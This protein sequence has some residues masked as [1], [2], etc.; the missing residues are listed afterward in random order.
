MG[1]ETD[2]QLKDRVGRLMAFL[3]VLVAAR[4]HPV[5]D[6]SS[7]ERVV[8]PLTVPDV[9]FDEEAL[10]GST[11][12][13]ANR[14]TLEAAP[15][16][17]AQLRPWL[18][19]GRYP[20][21][22]RPV[23]ELRRD[24]VEP[25]PETG[26]TR[27]LEP[28][29]ATIATYNGWRR[30]WSEWARS[31]QV[32]RPRHDFYQI[33]LTMRQAL[34]ERPESV[35]VVLAAGLL[36]VP[37]HIAGD[38]LRT[39]VLTQTLDVQLDEK[40]GDLLCTLPADSAPRLE[41]SQLLT[42][43]SIFDSSGSNYFRRQLSENVPSLATPNTVVFLKEWAQRALTVAVEVSAGPG[44][45]GASTLTTAPAI[46]LR[47]RGSAALLA[48]YERIIAS[49]EQPGSVVPLGLA[50]LVDAI[51]PEDRI[52][53]LERT[54]A[55]GAANLADDP[56]FPLPAN[57][58]QAQ[59][60]E[61]LGRDSG[62]V[63]EGPPG[64]GKTHTIANLMS[65]LLAQGQRV[66]VTSEKA[67]ALRV[68]REKLPPEM[69][70]LCVSITDIARGGSAELSRSVATLAARK[71][72]FNAATE[73]RRIDNLA[74]RRRQAQQERAL[75][76]EEIRSLRESETYQHPAVSDGYAGTA[77]AIARGVRAGAE[78][79]DW[80]PQ[81]AIGTAPL[82]GPE[83]AELRRLLSTGT[84]Q[85]RSRREQVLPGT[86]HLPEI[87]TVVRLCSTV[88]AAP[89][90]DE[91]S[92]ELTRALALRSDTELAEL[93]DLCR[94]VGTT[95]AELRRPATPGWA[96][97][98]LNDLLAGRNAYLWDQAQQVATAADRARMASE[99]VGQ[100]T[101]EAPPDLPLVAVARAFRQYSDYVLA[102]GSFRRFRKSDEQKAIEPFL[103][104][105]TIDGQPATAEPAAGQAASHF[106][107]LLAVQHVA[108]LLAPLGAQS[109]TWGHRP[110]LVGA[111]LQAAATLAAIGRTAAVIGNLVELLARLVPRPPGLH[112]LSSAEQLAGR[113]ASL[114]DA[115]AGK[116]AAGQLAR[117]VTD[118]RSRFRDHRSPEFDYL[119]AAIDAADAAAVSA[120]YRHLEEA[121]RQ[122]EAQRRC[123]ELSKRLGMTSPSML[124]SLE[125]DPTAD[126]WAERI[127]RWSDA[128]AWAVAA[129]WLR[130]R[131]QPGRE[132]QLE[133][134]L[135]NLEDQLSHTTA[136]LAA[137]MA[138]VG[139]L[140]RMDARQMQALQSYRDNLANVGMGTGKYAEQFRQAA[141]SAMQDA[142]GAVPAWVMP[143]QQVLASLPATQNLFDVVIVDEASQ[144]DITSL[145]L[146][147]LAPR[148]IVV[149]DDKQ[150]TP[151]EVSAG[152]LQ[153]V[154]SRLESF[155]PD[156][157]AL[158]PDPPQQRVLDVAH[159]VRTGC[160]AARALPLHAGD[161]QL[162]IVP[163]L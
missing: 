41:D 109:P 137:A 135:R 36:N 117:M 29:G 38:R 42:G 104:V 21:S 110:S 1:L 103:A 86:A 62:V 46:V 108:A 97:A 127:G 75:V 82:T 138:W 126:P 10:P 50:Q 149:G 141:R 67:Q 39:H 87:D 115:Y 74:S 151:S 94:K 35:E 58:E 77:A 59:I 133:E 139:A 11:V 119:T 76:L 162:V 22:S 84:D 53:W 9:F 25:D 158:H 34:N 80:V 28:D 143:I 153:G 56:L 19:T 4:T 48:F 113:A 123:D 130:H 105:I 144:V 161:H 121:R 7:H 15:E 33:L 51:E 26:G 60:I 140:Q 111:S 99:V 129:T 55:T 37:A 3:R 116:V 5:R 132:Q 78:T 68:L 124:A 114:S 8:W 134:R 91:T 79:H 112:S 159:T 155:L 27:S 106:E 45:G 6:V 64:T 54:G 17:P 93:A 30:L 145:F 107:A 83:L 88:G 70:E 160:P 96:E 147:W 73:T 13:R 32:N 136:Q 63:V 65:A 148:V 142:Q 66:L 52:A 92:D 157:P 24:R 81:P 69:Q 95:I 90:T 12:V 16:V 2:P 18:L 14:V 100:R 152:A 146:L 118:L 44:I 156:M 40:T 49:S 31:D 71:S 72:G 122:Q 61:R 125:A 43:L 20:D 57:P 120:G 150:C 101:V 98:V 47:R 163:V 102:G 89:P 85:R 131:Q 154:F 23:P 128:W